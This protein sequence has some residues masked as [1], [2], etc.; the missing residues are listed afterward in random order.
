MLGTGFTL[1]KQVL[2]VRAEL[3]GSTPKSRNM[4]DQ[5]KFLTNFFGDRSKVIVCDSNK[6]NDG[7]RDKIAKSNRNS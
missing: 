3:I 5:E 1:E 4:F 6:L 2:R 7:W